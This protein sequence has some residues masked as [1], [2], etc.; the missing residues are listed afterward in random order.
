[1]E[2]NY[3]RIGLLLL[4]EIY[5]QDFLPIQL[6]YFPFPCQSGTRTWI[7]ILF[8][9]NFLQVDIDGDDLHVYFSVSVRNTRYYFYSH[10][11]IVIQTLNELFRVLH[12][13]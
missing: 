2:V 6:T 11:L 9:N 1:M 3:C 10:S 5:V 8:L 13:D 4:C 12:S 7:V